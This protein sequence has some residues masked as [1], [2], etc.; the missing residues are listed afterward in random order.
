MNKNDYIISRLFIIIF[1]Q[2][3]IIIALFVKILVITF[4]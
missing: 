4:K 2:L 1:I 3:F